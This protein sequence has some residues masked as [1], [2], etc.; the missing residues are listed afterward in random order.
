MGTMIKSLSGCYLWPLPQAP[1][2]GLS[3][4]QVAF[5]FWNMTILSL[6]DIRKT[7]Q[8]SLNVPPAPSAHGWRKYFTDHANRIEAEVKILDLD[9]LTSMDSSHW[10]KG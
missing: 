3:V 5:C 2:E 4:Q 9:T 6:E 1:Y 7:P 8:S 10:Q